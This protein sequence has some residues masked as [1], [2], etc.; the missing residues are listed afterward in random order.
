MHAVALICSPQRLLVN[1]VSR[2]LCEM[3]RYSDFISFR[4]G[5]AGYTR[6]FHLPG[7]AVVGGTKQSTIFPPTRTTR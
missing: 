6:G 1:R 7:T 5:Y 2:M 3:L 4:E